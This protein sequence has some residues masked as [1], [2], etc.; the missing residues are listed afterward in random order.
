[1]LSAEGQK[2]MLEQPWL[3]F[4]PGMALATVIYG[5]NML[6]DAMRDL[7][8]PRLRSYVGRLGLP[9]KRNK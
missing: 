2:Y 8:D 9:K 6:G 3:A 1:M 5:I 4:R 7:I